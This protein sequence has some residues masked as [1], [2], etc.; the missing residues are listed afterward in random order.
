MEIFEECKPVILTLSWK[1]EKKKSRAYGSRSENSPC[2]VCFSNICISSFVMGTSPQE[3]LLKVET[4][5]GSHGSL[6]AWV[7]TVSTNL[8]KSDSILSQLQGIMF[9]SH[10][11]VPSRTLDPEA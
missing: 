9:V 1:L 6:L 5:C 8:N 3:Y 7:K 2:L 11:S 10:K 4:R